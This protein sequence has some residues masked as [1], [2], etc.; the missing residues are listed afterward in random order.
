MNI[1]F[2]LFPP[3]FT[4]GFPLSSA[5]NIGYHLQQLKG[6]VIRFVHQQSLS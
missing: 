2:P 5:E 1:V 4:M 3:N 6:D